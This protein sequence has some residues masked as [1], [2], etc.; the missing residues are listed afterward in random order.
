MSWKRTTGG[1]SKFVSDDLLMF[2][3]KVP[4]WETVKDRNVPDEEPYMETDGIPEFEEEYGDMIR[5]W[6]RDL[7]RGWWMKPV[8]VQKW[9]IYATYR[10]TRKSFES[11][12]FDSERE[13]LRMADIAIPKMQARR[14]PRWLKPDSDNEAATMR[15]AKRRGRKPQ[16][17]RPKKDKNAPMILKYDHTKSPG[18]DPF[19]DSSKHRRN[20]GASRMKNKV[21]DRKKK[22]RERL[23]ASAARVATMYLIREE[24]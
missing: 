6:E 24:G 23:H 9:K 20:D 16:E 15:S 19:S 18:K 17:N 1:S 12:P 10:P 5:D 3:L 8:K 22:H 14:R 4:V 13:A 11:D 21:L 2:V 7:A